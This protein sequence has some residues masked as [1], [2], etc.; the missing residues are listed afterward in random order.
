MLCLAFCHS[1]LAEDEGPGGHC[2][3]GL[4][5]SLLLSVF[6]WL[7]QGH[8]LLQLCPWEGDASQALPLIVLVA[9]GPDN[10]KLMGIH[11]LGRG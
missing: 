2:F 4:H 5:D 10:L 6:L 8:L 7:L 3:G 9:M 1:P 11:G